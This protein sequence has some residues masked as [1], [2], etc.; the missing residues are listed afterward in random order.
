MS[1]MS[2]DTTGTV[3]QLKDLCRLHGVAMSHQGKPLRKAELR[4]ALEAAFS[5]PSKGDVA[6]S[7]D[8]AKQA[9]PV[10]KAPSVRK[11]PE[12][13]AG[14]LEVGALGIGADN[15]VYVVNEIANGTHRWVKTPQKPSKGVKYYI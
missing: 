14:P 4:A 6:D 13:H 5:G 1:V 7:A 11:A 2:T 8:S 10:K 9:A 12:T 15:T 3:D